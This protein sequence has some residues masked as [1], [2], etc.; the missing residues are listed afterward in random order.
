MRNKAFLSHALL[1]IVT[2]MACLG[3]NTCLLRNRLILKV[4]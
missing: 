1:F 2:M 4:Y 3:Q